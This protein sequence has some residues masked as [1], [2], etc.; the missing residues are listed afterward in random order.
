MTVHR[1]TCYSVVVVK[2]RKMQAN[3]P[4]QKVEVRLEPELIKWLD[5]KFE[6]IPRSALLRKWITERA[7][8]EGYEE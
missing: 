5:T 6:L 1:V 7:K 4:K 3:E 2:K 8:A